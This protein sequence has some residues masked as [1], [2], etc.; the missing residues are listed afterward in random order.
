VRAGLVRTRY[1]LVLVLLLAGTGCGSSS[2]AREQ[3]ACGSAVLADWGEDGRIDGAYPETCYL[4]AIDSL[5]ED[6]RAYTSARD[7]IARALQSAGRSR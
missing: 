6:L 3:E 4:A 5:P 7:D 1:A 2:S